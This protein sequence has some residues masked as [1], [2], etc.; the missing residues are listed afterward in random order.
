V[1]DAPTT[2]QPAAAE[3]IRLSA[4]PRA[5]RSVRRARAGAGLAALLLTMLLSLQAGVPAWD[6]TARALVAGVAVHIAAWAVAVT[7]WRQLILA[8]LKAAHDR[9]AERA[10]A[11]REQLA[12]E[13]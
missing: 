5:V 11:R 10:R 4:H 2:V 9:R 1:S 12:A 7:V 6:A 8:E 3:P 13:A